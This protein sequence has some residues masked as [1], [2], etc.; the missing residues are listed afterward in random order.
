MVVYGTTRLLRFPLEYVPTC[1][2]EDQD[3]IAVG[4]ENGAVYFTAIDRKLLDQNVTRSDTA[5]T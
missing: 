5:E 3:Y 4:F 2:D 1:Y